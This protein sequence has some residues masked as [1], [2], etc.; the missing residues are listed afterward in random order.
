M[1]PVREDFD[2]PTLGLDWMTLRQPPQGTW[3][4][5]E[6]PGWLRLH[7]NA[8]CLNDEGTTPALVGRWQT[9]MT[10][11]ASAKLDFEPAREGDEAGLATY[12]RESHHYEVAVGMRR[13][14]R[15][16]FLRRRIHDLQAVVAEEEL[17]PGPVEL[18]CTA[19]PETYTFGYRSGSAPLR[20]LGTASIA[21]I[22]SDAACTFTGMML[23]LYATGNGRTCQAPAD[24]DW[25]EYLPCNS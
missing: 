14:V 3:S 18:V 4:L 17:P 15:V 22:S 19:T 23:A 25:F 5:D 24:F 2:S 13:G 10:C 21:P 9:E 1:P 20:I 11:K 6:R 8:S 12:M 7:G 16:V